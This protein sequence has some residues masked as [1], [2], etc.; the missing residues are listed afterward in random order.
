MLWCVFLSGIMCVKFFLGKNFA[1]NFFAEM[2]GSGNSPLHFF[3]KKNLCKKMSF[4]N[5]K[6]LKKC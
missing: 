4:K 2:F 3:Y 6:I 5:T 1:R